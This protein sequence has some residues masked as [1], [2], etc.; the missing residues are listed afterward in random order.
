[1]PPVE[2]FFTGYRQSK[3]IFKFRGQY[4]GTALIWRALHM[5]RSLQELGFEWGS[6]DAVKILPKQTLGFR[7]R[8][9]LSFRAVSLQFSNGASRIPSVALLASFR[10]K[11]TEVGEQHFEVLQLR[12]K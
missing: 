12:L 3:G 9:R 8:V 6:G 4:L 10:A 5:G 11:I 1:V 2:A 7:F